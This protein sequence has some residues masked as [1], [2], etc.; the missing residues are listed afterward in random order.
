MAHRPS[1][2]WK[3]LRTWARI[4]TLVVVAWVASWV[5]FPDPQLDFGVFGRAQRDLAF[6]DLTNL[7]KSV[8]LFQLQERRLP[9][10]LDELYVQ[11]GILD[12]LELPVDPWGNDYVYEVVAE[13]EFVLYS[14]GEDGRPGGEGD[15]ADLLSS[16]VCRSD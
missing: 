13:K 11:D 7:Q 6:Q 15:A 3:R 5:L 16:D 2:R 10:R 12:G 14:L 9:E 4:V 8:E 1:E